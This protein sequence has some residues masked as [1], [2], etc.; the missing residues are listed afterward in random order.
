MKLTLSCSYKD[1]CKINKTKRIMTFSITTHQN[2]TL[3]E[4]TAAGLVL[5]HSQ[6]WCDW[7]DNWG[8]HQSTVPLVFSDLLTQT[9]Q[10]QLVDLQ[11]RPDNKKPI[12]VTSSFQDSKAVV[13]C[14]FIDIP[15]GSRPLESIQ[16]LPEMCL[17]TVGLCVRQRRLHPAA[18][19]GGF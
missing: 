5:N 15:P 18:Q 2:N 14:I 7:F 12:T 19:A 6:Y 16:T 8:S 17:L 1:P 13:S 10:L 11:V 4:T 9:V 3:T